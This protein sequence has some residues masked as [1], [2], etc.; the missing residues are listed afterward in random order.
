VRPGH[1]P[2]LPR[3]APLEAYARTDRPAAIVRRD[4]GA[5]L[6]TGS[7][8]LALDPLAEEAEWMLSRP[9]FVVPELLARYPHRTADELRRLIALVAGA[10]LFVSYQ[11]K[12]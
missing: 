10:G 7:G 12:V 4:G 5:V 2:R 1:A 8:E 11:P 6:Q 9:A 3:R